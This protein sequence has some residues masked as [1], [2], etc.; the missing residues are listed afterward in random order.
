MALFNTLGF[1][2][3]PFS[4]TNADEEPSLAKYF[5]KPPFFDAIIGDSSNPSPSIILAPRGAGKTA[6]R[7]MVESHSIEEQFLAVTYDRFEFS[8]GESLKNISLQYHLKNIIKRIL[9]SLLS[10]LSEYPDVVKNLTKEERLQL[11]AYVNNYLGDLTGDRLQELISELKSL[12]EKF[13]IF[14]SKN[15]GFMEPVINFILKNYELETIDFPDTKIEERKLSETYKYQLEVLLALAKK[16][17][18][19]SIYVLTDRVDETEK[20][21]NNPEATYQLIQPL[22]KDLGNL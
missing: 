16:I 20:T 2:E 9:I 5:V 11:S 8:A 1:E 18:F 17:R 21:G 14:W 15:I 6:L 12:P 22:I 4:K 3:H 7:K 13:K 10:Y 19:K